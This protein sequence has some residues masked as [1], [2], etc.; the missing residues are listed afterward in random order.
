VK[1]NLWIAAGR[2]GS[3]MQ[4]DPRGLIVGFVPLPAPGGDLGTTNLAFGGQDNK[5][6]F[7]M[8]QQRYVLAL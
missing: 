8:G 3:L 5:E 7:V 1:G 2:L 4:V 6:I